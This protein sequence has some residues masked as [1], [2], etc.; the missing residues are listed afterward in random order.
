MGMAQFNRRFTIKGEIWELQYDTI[1]GDLK[2]LGKRMSS[3]SLDL[4]DVAELFKAV[5]MSLC[6]E[7]QELHSKVN[8]QADWRRW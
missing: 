2:I 7:I 1:T 6:N 3:Q 5:V 8:G 4:L